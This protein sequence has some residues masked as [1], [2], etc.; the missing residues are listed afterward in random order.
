[1][2]LMTYEEFMQTN[3]Y[4]QF[5]AENPDIG[6][7]KVMAFTAYQAVPIPEVEILIT[8]QIGENNVLFFRGYTDASGI[9]DNIPL[10]APPS[11]YNPIS[12]Q[13]SNYI[14]YELTAIRINYGAI[15]KYTVGMYGGIK[16]I[17]YIKMIPNVDLKGVENGNS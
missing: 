1:M 8:K 5:I 12:H 9:I 6:Y 7:L 13:T 3:D 11:G 15:K 4:A 2:N 16:T 10:P 17:Q 14:L